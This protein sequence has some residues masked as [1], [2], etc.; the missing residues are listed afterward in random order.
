MERIYDHIWSSLV[1]FC[2]TEIT[3]LKNAGVST[4]LIFYDFDSFSANQEFPANDLLGLQ[5]LGIDPDGRL[6]YISVNFMLSSKNDDTYLT[7]HRK[8]LSHMFDKLGPEK[9]IDLIH[10]DTGKVL[11]TLGIADPAAVIPI[12]RSYSRSLQALSVE[13]LC[14]VSL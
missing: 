2:Q 7:R 4:D 3:N 10:A 8:M 1:V 6:L 13:F 12:T 14:T 5:G 11:G 9:T